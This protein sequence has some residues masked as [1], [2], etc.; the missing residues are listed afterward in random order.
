LNYRKDAKG[1]ITAPFMPILL[2][3]GISP[4]AVT[5]IGLV[6]VIA[7]AGVT[8]WGYLLI[9]GILI[10]LAGYFDILDGAVAR[11]SNRITKFGGVLDSAF[12]RLSEAFS[13]LG[14]TWYLA[15]QQQII[16]IVLCFA[17]LTFSFLIS[18]IRSRAEG[19]GM[20]CEVGLFTRAERVILTAVGLIAGQFFSPAI[21]IML[22]ILVVFSFITVIQRLVH[23]YKRAENK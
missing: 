19:L 18:Y 1:W 6:I 17:A 9:G 23:V 22:I 5:V 16:E 4:N 10:L 11:N 20:N 13:L 21:L 2:K 14:L 15:G 12:D 8:A 7:A 3:T